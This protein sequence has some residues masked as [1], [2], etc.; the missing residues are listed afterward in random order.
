MEVE[1]VD[2]VRDEA[3]GRMQ[4]VR[5]GEKEVIEA[6]LVLLAMGFTGA[7]KTELFE[8]LGLEYDARGCIKAD[9]ETRATT[10]DGVF[11][12]GDAS[13]GASLVVRC[14]AS[15]QAAARGIDD[16]LIHH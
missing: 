12:A 16:Y 14:I 7:R 4:L 9:P 11:A 2:W 8:G 1:H 10:V 6:D 13:T 15:W 5:T 3:T